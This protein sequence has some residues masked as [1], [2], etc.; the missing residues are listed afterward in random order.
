MFRLQTEDYWT[1]VMRKSNRRIRLDSL[2]SGLPSAQIASFVVHTHQRLDFPP[3]RAPTVTLGLADSTHTKISNALG[4]T[5]WDTDEKWKTMLGLRK[6]YRKSR[7]AKPNTGW[8]PPIK[9]DIC[10]WNSPRDEC[11]LFGACPNNSKLKKRIFGSC[12][13]RC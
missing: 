4:F 10:A 7:I 6:K 13:K 8:N 12:S 5:L 3:P 11:D 9:Q 1:E 2:D